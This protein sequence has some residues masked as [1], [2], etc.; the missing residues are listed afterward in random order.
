[1]TFYDMFVTGV[2]FH[3]PFTSRREDNGTCV[4]ELWLFSRTAH[5]TTA[6]KF[7]KKKSRRESLAQRSANRPAV[8]LS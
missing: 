8:L 1:M 3:A 6:A 7:A 4:V 2:Q 5:L